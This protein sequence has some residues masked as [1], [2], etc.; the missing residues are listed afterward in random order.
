VATLAQPLKYGRDIVIKG[1]GCPHTSK[2]KAVDVLMSRLLAAPATA[3]ASP[4]ARAGPAGVRAELS[5]RFQT[6]CV[7][8]RWHVEVPTTDGGLSD[9][10][11]M[12]AASSQAA[13]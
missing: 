1:Q 5:A 9:R 10:T 6:G 3:L 7:R 12:I 8:S 11:T 13:A 2:H 4:Q